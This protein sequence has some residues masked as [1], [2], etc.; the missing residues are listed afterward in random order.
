MTETHTRS[1][2]KGLSWRVIATLTTTL[3]V[4]IYTG[5][6]A[7]TAKVGVLDTLLKLAFYFGHERTWNNVKWGKGII[8]PEPVPVMATA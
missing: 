4:Y 2:V 1:L 8:K 3:L 6:L 7:L 5:N